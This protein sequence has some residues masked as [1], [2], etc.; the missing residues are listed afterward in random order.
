MSMRHRFLIGGWLAAVAIA[1][2]ARATVAAPGDTL[3]LGLTECV[4]QALG[5]GEEMR[6]AQDEYATV[7][8]AYVQARSSAL[9]RLSF[10][11]TYTRAIKSAFSESADT[12]VKPFEPDTLNMDLLQRIR[13][14]E[15]ALPT[16]WLSGL[17]QLFSST[18]FASENTWV[19]SLGLT[20]TVFR[21][22][23][24]WNAIA[25][26]GHAL[27]AAEATRSDRENEIVLQVR[28][29]YLGALLADRSAH[30]AGLALSQSENQLERVRQRQEAGGASE[31]ELLQAEVQRGNQ[32]PLV[33]QA[34][35]M[36][37]VA[38]LELRRLVN[39]P[40]NVPLRLTTPL[41]DGAA[42]PA[43]PAVF[44][45]LGLVAA[46]LRSPSLIAAEEMSKAYRRA[47]S[48]A[49]ADRWP[50][51]SLY[52]NYSQQAYPKDPIPR[53]GDWFEDVNA[54]LRLDW[55]LF[56]GFLTQGAVQAAKAKQRMTE[57]GLTQAREGVREAVIQSEY[58]LQRSAADLEARARTVEL[59]RRAFE[60]ANIRYEEGAS[61]LLEVAD[62]R[63]AYQ[64]A[65]TNEAQ[66]RHD[67]F[68]ALARLE[69]YTG[70]PLFAAAAPQ[71]P[72]MP[73]GRSTR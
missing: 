58:D 29:A 28:Q 61:D 64:I 26:A 43:Q 21:G 18:G 23:S 54:G 73:A 68:V 37:Q 25:G 41:L 70:R 32:I 15:E 13:D 4:A 16:A 33:K 56:D 63:T 12:G 55:T 30:I 27:R 35:L 20:Q 11:T 40:V 48:V 52:A 10:S 59:A 2:P 50:G 49:A 57:N 14:L 42:M 5:Q 1:V 8:A 38:D 53:R 51:L 24:I 67:Y 31:F 45:T 19:A 6:Q 66:A 69:R 44:D 71:D 46:A 9:P 62:A 3:R 34:Q 65:Q 36:R 60:L 17:G 72:P 39:L 47:V 7:H 22:G